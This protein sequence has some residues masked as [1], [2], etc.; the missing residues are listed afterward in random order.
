MRGGVERRLGDEECV[1]VGECVM[2]GVMMDEGVVEDEF[3][4]ELI[5]VDE[6]INP[7]FM[8]GGFLNPLLI[9]DEFT[10]AFPTNETLPTLSTDTMDSLKTAD[11]FS[12][13]ARLDEIP[14]PCT[15][16]V[17]AT[18]TTPETTE[19]SPL[20]PIPDETTPDG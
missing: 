15:P 2:D 6:F 11:A 20:F 14:A 9:D 5:M 8:V 10:I 4:N 19:P 13:S 3:T 17:G 16:S 7:P 1:A 18:E 12:G